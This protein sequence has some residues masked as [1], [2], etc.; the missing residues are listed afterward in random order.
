MAQ[1]AHIRLNWLVKI[2]R[3]IKSM[4]KPTATPLSLTDKVIRI[5][6]RI[7]NGALTHEL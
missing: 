3:P 1:M 2:K 6:I 5:N 4:N 7:D